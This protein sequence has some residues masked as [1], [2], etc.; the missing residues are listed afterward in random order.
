GS[1]LMGQVMHVDRFGNL[2]TNITRAT[3]ETVLEKYGLKGFLASV[4]QVQCERHVEHYGQVEPGSLARVFGSS[5]YL[6]LVARESSAAQKIG[7]AV[8]TQVLVRF[9][10]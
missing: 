8:G 6:E 9:H 7:A 4:G 5:G 10:K 3:L 2:V 1:S